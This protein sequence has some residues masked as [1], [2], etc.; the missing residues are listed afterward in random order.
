[1]L[2][3]TSD[4]NNDVSVKES[5]GEKDNGHEAKNDE[6]D[7]NDNIIIAHIM[8]S[9]I[10]SISKPQK[11]VNK[12]K[13]KKVVDVEVETKTDEEHTMRRLVRTLSDEKNKKKKIKEGASKKFYYEEA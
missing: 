13:V 12:E 5:L 9:L 11:K 1:M 10:N 2:S 6:I 4:G 7:D 3:K 8:K